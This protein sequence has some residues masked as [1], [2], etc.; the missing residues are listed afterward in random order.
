MI[1]F[2][3]FKCTD[4]KEEQRRKKSVATMDDRCYNK[5]EKL[6]ALHPDHGCHIYEHMFK[7][8]KKS[9]EILLDQLVEG[10]IRFAD[11]K[12]TACKMKPCTDTEEPFVPRIRAKKVNYIHLYVYT[13]ILHTRLLVNNTLG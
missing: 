7:L 4:K 13:C 2:Y 10:T 5:F 6:Q 12:S 9:A 8:S 11:I 1:F 3:Y